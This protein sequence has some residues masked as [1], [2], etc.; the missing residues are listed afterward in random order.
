MS[1]PP[2]RRPFPHDL[3]FNGLGVMLGRDKEGGTAPLVGR[4][5]ADLSR[6]APTDFTYSAQSPQE[7]R[8]MP[9]DDFAL[10]YGLSLQREWQDRRC[11][12]C[13]AA[14]T[15]A[16]ILGIKGPDIPTVTPDRVDATAGVSG[17]FELGGDIYALN[18]RYV[19][20]R[21][22]DLPTGW[23]TLSK[24]FGEGKAATDA[25][26]LQPNNGATTYAY[27]AMGD[28][29]PIYSFEGTNWVQHAEASKL[30]ARKW[31][32]AGRELYRAL[33]TNQV[34]KVDVNSDPFV[35]A[36]WSADNMWV[37]GDK[38]HGITNLG[39]T[40]EGE[41][42]VAKA[43]G[44]YTVD[45]SGNSVDLYPNLKMAP[46]ADGGRAMGSWLNN[47]YVSYREGCFRLGSNDIGRGFVLESIGPEKLAGNNTELR[48]RIT[49][50]RGHDAF[51]LYAGL[52]N[53]DTNTSYLMKFGG[54]VPTQ[55]GK[56]ER[57]DS[58]H[59]SI[60]VAYEGKKITALHKSTVGAPAGHSRMYIGFSDGT[61]AWFVLPCTADPSAC[62][63]YKFTTT[64]GR[65]T[66]PRLTFLF[67]QEPKALKSISVNGRNLSGSAY[68]RVEYRTNPSA[69]LTVL[70]GDFDSPMS[71]TVQFPVGTS[72]TMLDLDLVLKNVTVDETPQITGVGIDHILRRKTKLLYTFLVLADDGLIK[73]NGTPFRIGAD[74]IKSLVRAAA[75]IAEGVPVILPD[76]KTL[77]LFV[78]DYGES[79]GWDERL[80][81][82]RAALSV[83]AMEFEE[84]D[85]SGTYN[86]LAL[87][88]YGQLEGF[89]Y[90]QLRTL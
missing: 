36:N 87:Y 61:I 54:W 7:G 31:L 70:D 26:V 23:D 50:L 78:I 84:I 75:D 59:G 60:S 8:I 34:S 30:Y 11:Q 73:R 63:E 80:R 46:E 55:G 22:S 85:L 39:A 72:G 6:V 19:F 48:G 35:Y 77:R 32:L 9:I 66:F 53:P 2:R 49:A 3:I 15:S 83:Q 76:E 79:L 62:D 57:I 10:G 67:A 37:I 12:K 81:Q 56:M 43:D 89:T 33:A 58:W 28:A 42:I 18:G 88:T 38:L 65:I 51:N 29:E 47:L 69:A 4:K 45:T 41:V 5:P 27:V 14:D 17:F 86:R 13:I 40:V 24:D 82:W 25:V 71:E 90:D 64:D 16:G 74:R 1:G 20:K 44:L 52:W 21:T 68:A